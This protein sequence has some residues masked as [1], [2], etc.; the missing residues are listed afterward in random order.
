[1]LFSKNLRERRTFPFDMH[2]HMPLITQYG[3][4]YYMEGDMMVYFFQSLSTIGLVLLVSKIMLRERIVII[5]D[6]SILIGLT[7]FIV[8][9]ESILKIK[10][11]SLGGLFLLGLFVYFFL[12]NKK[13]L[14]NILSLSISMIIA[15]LSD[16]LSM[17][18]LSVFIQSS[19]L[20]AE[21]FRNNP[22]LYFVS[23]ILMFVFSCS[24]ALALRKLIGKREQMVRAIR[25]RELPSFVGLL[26]MGLFLFLY[27]LT[28]SVT[29]YT[30]ISRAILLVIMT[31]I[32]SAILIAALFFVKS[33]TSIIELKSKENELEQLMMYTREIETMHKEIRKFKHDYINILASLSGYIEA[34]DMNGLRAYFE[35]K[36]VMVSQKNENIDMTLD[37]LSYLEQLELKGLFALK[38]LRAQDAGIS[39]LIQIVENIRIDMDIVELC[40]VIGIFM[41]NA[42]EA[43]ENTT[44]PKITI[45]VI[46]RSD[47]VMVVISNTVKDMPPIYKLRENG[48]TSKGKQ[49]GLGLEI[50]RDILRK[51]ENITNDLKYENDTFTQILEIFN[52]T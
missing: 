35:D 34:K 18:V 22:L 41:D 7:S 52:Y 47:R 49:R 42:I 36:I 39:V 27:W 2:H 15:I 51:Y 31:V 23:L 17:T 50:V 21:R 5:K 28:F 9:I 19:V 45:A 6:L 11:S 43:A 48:F 8:L 12:S 20:E 25:S 38:V 4:I 44:N 37:R 33:R 40:R 10:E 14:I 3:I 26:A 13:V 16:I 30:T 1:M 24:I 46:K 29:S 32:V